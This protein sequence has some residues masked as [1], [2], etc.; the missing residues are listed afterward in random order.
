MSEF[1]YSSFLKLDSVSINLF[2]VDRALSF[3]GGEGGELL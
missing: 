1:L 2:L 3:V